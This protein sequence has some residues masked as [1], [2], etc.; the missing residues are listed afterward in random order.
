MLN[1]TVNSLSESAASFSLNIL[2]N[3]NTRSMATLTIDTNNTIAVGQEIIINDD[4]T[5]IFAGTIDSYTKTFL[6][7]TGGTHSRRR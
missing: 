6:R 5:K 2:D 1:M 4:F 7:G 3:I